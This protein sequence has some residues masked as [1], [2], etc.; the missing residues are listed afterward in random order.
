M[1]TAEE[2]VIQ[3]LGSPRVRSSL[4]LADGQGE[5]Y[6]ALV[7]DEARVRYQVET[8]TGHD[9][10]DDVYFE[11]A[12]PRRN[13]FFEPRETKA[14]VVSCGSVCPGLNNVIRSAVLEFYYNYG[15]R[16]ILGIRYGFAGLNPKVGLAP[17]ELTPQSV[18]DIHE[19]GGTVLGSSRGKQPTDW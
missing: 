17:I 5:S 16:R 15:V 10:P 11:K 7:P 1:I 4:Q 19:K 6:G 18:S 2:T 12:G 9:L 8:G 14:A 3:N 13:L